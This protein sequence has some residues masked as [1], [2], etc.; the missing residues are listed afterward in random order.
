MLSQQTLRGL[1]AL[2]TLPDTKIANLC[3]SA[4]VLKVKENWFDLFTT[5]CGLSLEQTLSTRQQTV[6]LS[7][8]EV[9]CYRKFSAEN[10]IRTIDVLLASL[11]ALFDA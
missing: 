7:F 9:Q 3:T 1:C 6:V 10:V 4:D 5:L 8:F 11:D 2:K